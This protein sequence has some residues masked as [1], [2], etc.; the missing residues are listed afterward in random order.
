M[1]R[2]FCW[3]KLEKD[4]SIFPCLRFPQTTTITYTLHKQEAGIL[5]PTSS[6]VR[7]WDGGKREF[8][9]STMSWRLKTQT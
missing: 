2:V 7:E 4:Y 8:K 3:R 6:L 1:E 9:E 5:L